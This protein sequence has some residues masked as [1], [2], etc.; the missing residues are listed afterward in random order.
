[1]RRT[2][3]S[4]SVCSAAR[5]SAA[6][7]WPARPSPSYAAART[8]NSRSAAAR[9]STSAVAAVRGISPTASTARR[10]SATSGLASTS[11]MCGSEPSPA[12]PSRR[13]SWRE[14]RSTSSIRHGAAAPPSA[15]R[16]VRARSHSGSTPAAWRRKSSSLACRR[17]NATTASRVSMRASQRAVTGSRA[18]SSRRAA[19]AASPSRYR[20]SAAPSSVFCCADSGALASTVAGA[21]RTAG[22]EL[23][24]A[25]KGNRRVGLGRKAATLSRS[26]P[27]PNADLRIERER[28][29][30]AFLDAQRPFYRDDPDY[31]P[32]LTLVDAAQLAPNKNAFF[33]TAK[34]GFWL[35]REGKRC[36]GRISTVRNLTHDEFWGDRVGFFGHFEAASA[37]AAHALLDHAAAWLRAE[38]ATLLRGPIDLSTNYRTG[39]LIEGDA[40]PP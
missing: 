3:G 26:L 14:W 22:C 15:R 8:V 29:P 35:A 33:A 4:G 24:P 31:V 30:R 27:P 6:A 13:R 32:P 21:T 18:S 19:N 11:F 20:R 25:S 34:A 23:Q 5:S 38:G 10:R 40:G 2:Y 12:M 28:S 16:W 37:A 9:C 17:S 1:M 39:L 36:V 7:G